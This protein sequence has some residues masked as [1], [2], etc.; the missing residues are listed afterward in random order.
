MSRYGN[1]SFGLGGRGV[2][3]VVSLKSDVRATGTD[4]IG[5]WNIE[6]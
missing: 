1:V 6:L 3:P 4:T 2:R 5:S